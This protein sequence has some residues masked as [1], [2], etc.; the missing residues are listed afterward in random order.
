MLESRFQRID[1]GIS[2]R[3]SRF[4]LCHISCNI[5][6]IYLHSSSLIGKIWGL[7]TSVLTSFRQMSGLFQIL[8]V[9]CL[10][11]FSLLPD[12]RSYM[13]K[14]RLVLFPAYLVLPFLRIIYGSIQDL[15]DSA[16]CHVCPWEAEIA[17]IIRRT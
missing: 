12:K 11:T 9:Y 4:M 5:H 17:V 8:K 7:H 10:M 3:W 2:S 6:T 15:T 14:F 13:V 1:R 16:G